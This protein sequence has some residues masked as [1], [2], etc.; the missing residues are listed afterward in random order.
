MLINRLSMI[1][2]LSIVLLFPLERYADFRVQAASELNIS[3]NDERLHIN[4]INVEETLEMFR[5]NYVLERPIESLRMQLVV[6]SVEE[7]RV[8]T[9]PS[10]VLQNLSG[11]L[12]IKKNEQVERR[13]V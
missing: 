11:S 7:V 10:A 4:Q 2:N 12:H 8:I 6:E 13:K 9:N 5:S 3:S 1:S